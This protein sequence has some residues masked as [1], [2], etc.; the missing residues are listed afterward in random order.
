MLTSHTCKPKWALVYKSNNI[1]TIAK[2]APKKEAV[3]DFLMDHLVDT[4]I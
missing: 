4:S 1:V 2:D 3:D